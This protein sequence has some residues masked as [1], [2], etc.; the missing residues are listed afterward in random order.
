MHRWGVV[1]ALLLTVGVTLPASADDLVDCEY[2]HVIAA[3]DRLA[4]RG[5]PAIRLKLAYM[6]YKGEGVTQNYVEAMKWYR[7][8]AEEG[9][10]LG[11]AMLGDMYANGHGAPRDYAA[12]VK[13]YREGA[14]RGDSINQNS[15][16]IMY[17]KGQGVPQD[18][19]QAHMWFNLSAAQGNSDAA[20]NRALV[21]SMMTPEQIANAQALAAAWKP[22]TGPLTPP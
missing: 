18:Y 6:Y 10:A 1:A 3:C 19:V 11:Q 14:N 16:G 12:A 22:T 20:R 8:V 5:N 2:G 13:W 9:Y 17:A 7:K 4:E 15:L 21:A